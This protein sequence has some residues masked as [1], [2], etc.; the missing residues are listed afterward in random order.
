MNLI[1]WVKQNQLATILLIIFVFFILKTLFGNFY[2]YNLKYSEN[3]VMP[4]AAFM[5]EE[6]YSRDFKVSSS[7]QGT[8]APA[9]EISQRMVIQS[10]QLSLL[11]SDVKKTLEAISS[12]TQS[13]GGYMVESTLDRPEE[14]ASGRITVRVPQ[15]KLNE[16]LAHF[17]AQAVK[18]VSQTLEGTDVTDEYVDNQARLAILDQNKTRFEEI[19]AKAVT[20]Q[21]ILQVQNEIFNL[22]SQIDQIKG[23]QEYL[24]KNTQMV[25]ITIY[26]AEDE[27][28]L[29]YVP[30]NAWRPDVIFKQ[31]VRNLISLLRGLGSIVIWIGVFSVLWIPVVVGVIFYKKYY[32]KKKLAKNPS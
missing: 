25:R 18:V 17:N 28:S 3:Y 9:P 20:V 21:E 23:Q 13:I 31:A 8:A 10:S 15:E 5:D 11:V 12:Y 14:S 29:P 24:Q 19:M 4:M 30:D 22:Q 26:L 27:L 32:T 1:S 7:T 2:G 16:A 6:S